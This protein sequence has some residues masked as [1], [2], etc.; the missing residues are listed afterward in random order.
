MRVQLNLA[1]HPFGRNRTFYAASA[2]ASALLVAVAVFLAVAFVRSYQASPE[3]TRQQDDYRRQLA[4]LAQRQAQL[5]SVLRQPQNAAVL[6]RSL[7]LNDLLF[8]KGISWTRTFSDLE[9][10]MPPR[11][12]LISIRPQVTP[13]NDVSLEMQIGAETRESFI[14]FLK[15]LEASEQFHSPVLHGD[16]PPTD[17]LPLFRFRVTVI[18]E[19]KL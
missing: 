17:N 13:E 4:S 19:Q 18:Y 12:R 9:Q 1:T 7:F 11:A 3:L 16:A 15:S 2:F 6:E 8:R 5:E 10:L 14:E